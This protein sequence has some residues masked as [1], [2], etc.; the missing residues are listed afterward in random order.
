MITIIQASERAR[1]LV[2]QILKHVPALKRLRLSSLDT[3]EA[4]RRAKTPAEGLSERQRW[5]DRR[6]MAL[7]AHK[8]RAGNE[9]GT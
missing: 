5:R 4:D 6:L 3:I 1:D 8:R 9:I 2:K 7:A